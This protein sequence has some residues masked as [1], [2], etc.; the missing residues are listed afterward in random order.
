MQLKLT[1]F[2]DINL[3][4]PFFDSLKADYKEFSAWFI[5]KAEDSVYIFQ[6]DNGELDGMLYLKLEDGSQ[7]DLTPNLPAARRIKVGTFKIN[8]HG[9]KLGERFL[10]KF[11]T[12]P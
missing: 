10:K 4:D 11:L 1:Q 12:M 2:K 6:K 9:T 8:A 5:K 7:E 3:A